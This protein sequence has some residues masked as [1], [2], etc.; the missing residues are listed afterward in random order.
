MQAGSDLLVDRDTDFTKLP[1]KEMLN[2]HV[3]WGTP[4]AGEDDVRYDNDH[5]HKNSYVYDIAQ[6]VDP[7]TLRL[8]MPAKVTDQVS[9]SIGRRAFGKFRVSNCEFFLL[10]T[11][12]ERGLHDVKHRDKPGLSMIGLDQPRDWLLKSMRESDADFFFVIST[13]PFMIPHTGSGGAE[14]NPEN[15]EESLDRVF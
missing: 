10:D 2:L 6:V 14:L 15:K 9:Y 1:L 7:H 3:H 11:R 13:V 5:G 12:G 4:Q 8:H